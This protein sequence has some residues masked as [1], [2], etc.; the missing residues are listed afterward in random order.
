MVIVLVQPREVNCFGTTE[1]KIEFVGRY[2]I[3]CGDMFM[4]A[5]LAWPRDCPSS[6]NNN[7]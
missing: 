4:S 1:E 5:L 2:E 3:C 7:L 6:K